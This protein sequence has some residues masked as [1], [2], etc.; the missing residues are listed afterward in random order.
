M[1]QSLFQSM[2]AVISFRPLAA[3][4]VRTPHLFLACLVMMCL[5]PVEGYAQPNDTLR[6]MM[7]N[8]LNFPDAVPAGRA[9]TFK[10]IAQATQPDLLLIC[11]LKTGAGA[12][13]LLDRGLNTDGISRYRRADYVSN[14]SS[15]ADLQNMAIY[16]QDK[17]ALYEQAVLRTQVR[18]INRYTFFFRDPFL[19]GHRDTTWLDAYVLHFKAGNTPG[20]AASRGRMADTLRAEIY[21][22]GPGR[23]VIVGGDFNVYT[24]AEYAYASL[25]DPYASVWMRDPANRTGSW[26]NNSSFADVHTQS[27]RTSSIFGDGSGGG[28]DD[29]FDF[30]LLSSNV[31]VG[32]GPIAYVADS[33]EAF[34]NSGNCFNQTI[35]SCEPNPVSRRIR[36]ALYYQSDHLP[37]I[38][39]LAVTYP[40]FN[41]VGT[42]SA[43]QSGKAWWHDQ[44]MRWN[45]PGD[46]RGKWQLIDL[47]GRVVAFG[48]T[49]GPEGSWT[50]PPAWIASTPILLWH[51]IGDDG[52]LISHKIAPRSA[53]F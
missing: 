33:Y 25:D 30:L 10:T 8:L 43:S 14:T 40:I 1:A 18:D 6:V 21:R 9:D 26:N 35:F 50:A 48:R 2:A 22:R 13:L 42:A 16:N 44:T 34:G 11:E 47:T 52:Q 4:K 15:G 12:D 49:A 23:S 32:S 19:A 31:L 17:L 5:L 27:T 36:S 51:W 41:G 46:G 28:L 53:Y 29:R 7:Y 39:D 37:V 38:L 45:L 24:S 3:E 20:D